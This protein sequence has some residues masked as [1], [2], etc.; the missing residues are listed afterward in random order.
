ME[1]IKVRD[2]DHL[3]SII[4]GSANDAD[5]NHLDVSGVTDMSGLF[6]GSKFNGDIS[7][8]DV[9]NVLN[10][11]SMF[12]GSRFNGDISSWNVSNVINMNW[13]FS[14]S[15]FNG[16]ISR[17]T[18]SPMARM[19]HMFQHSDFNG[20]ISKWDLSKNRFTPMM[21]YESAHSSF[22]PVMSS[23]DPFGPCS[24]S[25]SPVFTLDIDTDPP[26]RSLSKF[27]EKVRDSLVNTDLSELFSPGSILALS[28]F[29]VVL[30][31]WISLAIKS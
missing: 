28:A 15:K 22:R 20:D 19:A 17:W 7:N 6:W 14:D 10:M 2:R 4:S 23:M 18:I 27:S 12:Q 25:G 13:M 31:C 3:A 11:D 29:T 26:R 21:F 9:S 24:G 5:L 16:D 1:M 30:I 8:W